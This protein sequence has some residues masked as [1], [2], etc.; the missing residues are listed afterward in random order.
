MTIDETTIMLWMGEVE[1]IW[2]NWKG[3]ATEVVDVNGCSCPSCYCEG[4]DNFI[5]A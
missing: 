4:A 5:L 3:D 2:C 1:C